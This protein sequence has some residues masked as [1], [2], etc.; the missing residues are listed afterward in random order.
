MRPSK[1]RL[2]DRTAVAYRSRAMISCWM[3]G[4][5]APDI[6]LHVV[7]A[8]ATTPKPSDSSSGIK[9]ASSRY[10]A[11]VLEPGAS[12]DFTH[13]LRVRPSRFA[14][15]AIRPAAIMLRGLLVLVQLVIAAMMTAPSGIRP[16]SFS[17]TPEMPRAASSE[18]GTRLWG[19]DGPAIL[20]TTVDRSKLI[21]RSY[22][23]P[24]MPS[25][26]RPVVRA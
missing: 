10:R 12:E 17:T 8:K 6:P 7:Q 21:T 20:R 2:P 11:T 15:R 3:T 9:P 16:A 24:A 1:L 22:T 23:A 19:L 25:A 18:V 26:H 13:G 5:R 14:L 4:S